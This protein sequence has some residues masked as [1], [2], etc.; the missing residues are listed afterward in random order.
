[1]DGTPV[2]GGHFENQVSQETKEAAST[3][4]LALTIRNRNSACLDP[5]QIWRNIM[6]TFAD[7]KAKLKARLAEIEAAEKAD[8]DKRA[9]IAGRVVL[10][11]AESDPA[12][13][14]QLRQML[15]QHLTKKRERADFE[16]KPK[17][18]ATTLEDGGR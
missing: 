9:L 4:K 3:L 2:F 16:L 11:V 15:D 14:D 6:P 18:T 17:R 10:K 1:M 7:E 13:A 5:L 8:R 12:F